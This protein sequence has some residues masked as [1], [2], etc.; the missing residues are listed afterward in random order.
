MVVTGSRIIN[1]RRF[2]QHNGM[3]GCGVSTAVKNP[4][5]VN[6]RNHPEPSESVE[7]ASFPFTSTSAHVL[8][9]PLG[10]LVV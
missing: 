3:S 4:T 9:V 5:N 8:P 7:Y 2:K 10:V 1:T 6:H